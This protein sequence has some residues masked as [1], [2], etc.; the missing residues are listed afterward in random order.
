MLSEDVGMTIPSANHSDFPLE[1]RRAI[2]KA[3]GAWGVKGDSCALLAHQII[4]ALNEG[5]FIV[6]ERSPSGH[7]PFLGDH[8]EVMDSVPETITSAVRAFAF[9]L[10]NR[11]LG[12]GL[13]D[14][15][16]YLDPT[17]PGLGSMLEMAFSVFVNNLRLDSGGIP[18]NEDAASKR[19]AQY[20]R[21]YCDP[22][23]TV[24]PPFEDWETQLH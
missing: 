12:R 19:A 24:E 18:T 7:V 20:L 1:A 14:D 4:T 9:V 21:S 2:Q 22:A 3:V 23:Y 16:D 13:L 15:V 6:S 11:T 5:G 10:G 8:A 17:D